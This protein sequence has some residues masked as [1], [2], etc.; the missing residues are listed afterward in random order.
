MAKITQLPLA[1]T[2]DGSETVVMV[3]DNITR[4][5][6]LGGLVGAAVAPHV[7]AAELARDQAAQ[8]VMPENRFVAA[9]LDAAV[10]LGEAGTETGTYFIAVGE[11]EGEAEVR[12]R[13]EDGSDLIYTEITKAA[14]GS[15]APGKGAGLVAFGT[16]TV[17]DGLADVINILD[18]GVIADNTADNALALSAAADEARSSGKALY[19]PR[20]AG[21]I[22]LA[23]AV[24][25][26]GI[27][28]IEI[29]A[30]I[31]VSTDIDDV[32]ITLGGFA[33]GGL[34][35][36]WFADII[37][38]SSVV[39]AA[40]PS[41]PIVRVTGAKSG[42][43][44][45]GSCNYLQFYADAAQGAPYASTAYNQVHLD[46]VT[47]LLEITDSGSAIGGGSWINENTFTGGRIQR[48][49]ITGVGYAHNHNKFYDNT[50]EGAN[51]EL[52]FEQAYANRIYGARFENVSGAPGAIFAATA[53]SNTIECTWSGTGNPRAEFIR[54]IGVV[55]EGQGNAVY[56]QAETVFKNVPL[57]SLGGGSQIISTATE[58]IT[59]NP[60]IC[61]VNGGID[62]IATRAVLTPGFLD[63]SVGANRYVALTEPIPVQRGDVVQFGADFDGAL[64]RLAIFV[65]DENMRPLVSEG[66]GGAFIS[67]LSAGFTSTYGR[68]GSSGN[69]TAAQ[70]ELAAAAII[71]SEVKFI[72]V[73]VYFGVAARVRHI[74][75][76]LRVQPFGR[77]RALD[78]AALNAPRTLG[79]T[80]TMG[81]A[82]YGHTIFDRTA[83]AIKHVSFQYETALLA[84]TA[85][86]GTTLTVVAATGVANGDIVGVM[87]DDQSV[88]W[89]SVSGLSG[90][91]FTIAAIP[92]GRKAPTGARV[93]FNRWAV[94]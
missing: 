46:G 9:S 40:P 45:F 91:T 44:H 74:S 77:G 65:L 71:R 75:A 43:M 52:A 79:G 25:L 48:L 47:S 23:S 12:L 80:P 32:P 30:N 22:Y 26:T 17:F 19:C 34:V 8:L 69:L 55:D 6:A 27:R 92:T 49:R 70:V 60:R 88:H 58:T 38:G 61:P 64:A 93:V 5:A 86:A 16:R 36:W 39:T 20:L 81:F 15:S 66:A 63:F 82:P 56:R 33:A 50:F 53:Y 42:A 67:Q 73:G 68:Y 21:S 7:S 11:A 83:H 18:R 29:N 13:T 4:R 3:K 28:E 76:G 78:F 59:P 24:D 35:D 54:A 37:D 31:R 51:T 94:L 1:A 87:L 72:R 89:S 62:N 2:P 57:F 10:T 90:S 41:R 85:A 14:F 84:E